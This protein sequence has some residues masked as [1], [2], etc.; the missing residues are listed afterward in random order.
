MS[1]GQRNARKNPRSKGNTKGRRLS[2]MARLA[3][4]ARDISRKQRR[5]VIVKKGK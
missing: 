4:V 5:P 3:I 2:G 1:K